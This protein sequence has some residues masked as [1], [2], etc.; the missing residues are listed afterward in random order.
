MPASVGFGHEPPDPGGRVLD[1]PA[2]REE[3]LPRGGPRQRPPLQLRQGLRL[4]EAHLLRLPQALGQLHG[5][6]RHRGSGNRR[7]TAGNGRLHRGD[8]GHALHAL[9]PRLPGLQ[10]AGAGV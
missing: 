7:G 9:R 10:G 1:Q 4:R 5:G 3:A 6:D 2:E 8:H